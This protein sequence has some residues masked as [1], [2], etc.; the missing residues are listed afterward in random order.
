MM[1]LSPTSTSADDAVIQRLELWEKRAVT[2]F[3]FLAKVIG[4]SALLIIEAAMAMRIWQLEMGLGSVHAES[5]P[6]RITCTCQRF[7]KDSDNPKLSPH[8]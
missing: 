6:E 7:A 1:S 2:I 3:L 4:L 5:E 8:R